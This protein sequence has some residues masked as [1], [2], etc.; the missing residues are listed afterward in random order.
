VTSWGGGGG[1][2][3]ATEDISLKKKKKLMRGGGKEKID[4]STKPP[5]S[6]TT[7]GVSGETAFGPAERGGL[8]TVTENKQINGKGTKDH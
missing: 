8:G 7:K 4:T 5:K 2:K 1:G 6:V 3:Q